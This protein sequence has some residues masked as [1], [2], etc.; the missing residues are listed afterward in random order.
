MIKRKLM[1]RIALAGCLL[2]A[3]AGISRAGSNCTII[4]S[5]SAPTPGAYDQSQL[6]EGTL[7]GTEPPGLNYYWNNGNPMG[8]TFTTGNNPGGYI[9]NSLAIQTDGGGGGGYAN[10]APFN[11]RIYQ[12]TGGNAVLVQTLESQSLALANQGDWL[13]VTNLDVTVALLPSTLYAYTFAGSAGWEELGNINNDPY[14]GGTPCDIPTGG[15]AVAYTTAPNSYNATFDVGLSLPTALSVNA[16]T[17]SAANP[18][19]QGGTVTLTPGSIIGGNGNYNYQWQQNN[20]SGGYTNIPGATSSTYTVNTANLSLGNSSFQVVVTESTSPFS[21]ATSATYTVIVEQLE[22]G[23]LVNLGSTAPTPS[24]YDISQLVDGYNTGDGLNYYD[25]NG[26][27]PGEV[28]TTGSNAKGYLLNSLA[29]ELNYGSSGTTT[30]T[31]LDYSLNIYSISTDGTT[32]SLLLSVTNDGFTYSY[33][34]WLK[35]SFP[36]LQLNPNSQYAYTFSRGTQGGYAGLATDN[37]GDLYPGGQICCIPPNGG[38]VVYGNSGGPTTPGNID[39]AFDIGLVPL[40]LSLVVNSPSASQNPVYALSPVTLSDSVFLPTNGTFVYKWLTDDGSGATP[41]NYIAVPNSATNKLVVVPPNWNPGGTYTTN[42]YF[43]ASVG[44][45]YATSG[46][47]VL[48]VNGASVPLFTVSQFMSNSLVTFAGQQSLVLSVA[49]AGTTPITNQWQIN[50]VSLT[51]QTNTTL[52]L[53][54]LTTSDTGTI[55]VAATNKVGPSSVG[56]SVTVA[57]APAPPAVGEK[58][59]NLVLADKPYAYWRLNEVND[60]TAANAPTYTA[61][62]WSGNG[63]DAYYGINVYVNTP[64][65]PLAGPQSPT[66]PGFSATEGAVQTLETGG[67]NLTVPALNLA[68]QTNIT[69]IAWI[70]PSGAQNGATGLLFNRGGPDNACGFGYGNNTDNLGYTWDNNAQSTWSWNSGVVVADNQW[71][72]VA[73]VI[74]PN[75][76]TVYLGNLNNGTTNFALASNPGAN[77]SETFAG[78]TILL[79]GDTSGLNRTFSGLMAEAALFTN[80]LSLAQVQ[81]LF[82]TGIGATALVPTVAP[83][84]LPT[85]TVYAGQNVLLA[86]N[87]GG[88]APLTLKWQS[89]PDQNIWANVPGGTSANL[90]L[91]SFTVGTTYYRLQAA[92]SAGSITSA[93][94][95]VTYNALPV[96]PAGLWTANYQITNNLLQ[97]TI[98]VGIGNYVGRGLLGTGQYWNIIP[99]VVTSL[100]TGINLAGVSDLADDGATHTGIYAK[101]NNASGGSSLAQSLPN[102]TDIGNLLDQYVQIYYSPGALQFTGVPDG[103]YNLALYGIDGSYGDRGVTFVVYDALNGNHTNSTLNGTIN[104]PAGTALAAGDNVALFT[105]VHVSG[106]TLTVDIDANPAA[107]GGANTEADFNAAQIQLVSYDTPAPSVKLSTAFAAASGTNHATLTVSWPEGTLLTATNLS[108]PWTPIYAPSPLKITATN[109][110][111]FFR[112]S[113]Q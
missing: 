27:A 44:N 74:T 78:G 37:G 94:V 82:L 63:F 54:N 36:A 6:L 32:A 106:G 88:S 91:N 60:P 69:F 111:Q 35:W 45:S 73:Y 19:V 38:T 113:V 76:A 7:N 80:A 61:Y 79:G 1:G 18:I 83:A 16:P 95:Q 99:D 70:N 12:I 30:G 51:Q 101:V 67:G 24:S 49:E 112:S 29:L 77:I 48:T 72:F 92:N 100:Y 25:N 20:S 4:E 68:G 97:G 84:A 41:P 50:G 47:V 42:Y 64:S 39:G 71:N 11:V 109:T 17:G 22:A 43:V 40:G 93:P 15:G 52:T 21:T 66:F 8:S 81:Q 98:G 33:G 10:S 5:S 85:N 3:A 46:P 105:N 53:S 34:A 58:Y 26:N 89:S 108:G 62:D 13:Q 110:A 31:A 9:L 96:T 56:V 28:F 57:P 103:T 75:N 102:P 104:N 14:P 59:A 107:K 55:Q 23:T 65:S 87:V 86:G 90:L 2:L